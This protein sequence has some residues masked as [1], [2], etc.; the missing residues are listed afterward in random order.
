V[1]ITSRIDY[2]N[3]VPRA[4]INHIPCVRMY[5]IKL[6]VWTV[7][8]VQRFETCIKSNWN[9]IVFTICRLIWNQTDVRLVSNQSEN[10][11]YNPIS[12][13][14]NTRFKSW[15]VLH[16]SYVL[17]HVIVERSF[18]VGLLVIINMLS[19]AVLSNYFRCL[20]YLVLNMLPK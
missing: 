13:W 9:Q 4:L 7:R 19:H 2:L 5:P 6:S 18:S 12:V 17:I 14:F 3:A 10:G 20:N 16:P 15:S 8:K 1:R 11:K